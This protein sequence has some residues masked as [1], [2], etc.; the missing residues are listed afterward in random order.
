MWMCLADTYQTHQTKERIH[1]KEQNYLGLSLFY[2][3]Y[4]SFLYYSK[5]KKK[6]NGQNICEMREITLCSYSYS[7]NRIRLRSIQFIYQIVFNH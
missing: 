1:R 7:P 3:N 6:N 5:L 2:N 4:V